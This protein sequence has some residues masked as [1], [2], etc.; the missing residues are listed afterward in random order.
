MPYIV[1]FPLYC[2]THCIGRFRNIYIITAIS[3]CVR[4]Y[5]NGLFGGNNSWLIRFKCYEF[6]FFILMEYLAIWIES[7]SS[8][9]CPLSYSSVME[10]QT[11]FSS[12][13]QKC[14]I[15][16]NLSK[17]KKILYEFCKYW[18]LQWQQYKS[19]VAIS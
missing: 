10:A 17:K 12:T 18:L 6:A 1:S 15:L 4:W 2:D 9:C 11:E 13:S 8:Q 7:H 3:V 19:I 5:W 14:L 16:C